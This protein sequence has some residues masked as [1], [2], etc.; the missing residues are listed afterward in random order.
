MS[1]RIVKEKKH[2][3]IIEAVCAV[4]PHWRLVF[5]TGGMRYVE[6]TFANIAPVKEGETSS[7]AEWV[8]GVA[9][10]VTRQSADKM[11]KEEGGGMFYD[12]KELELHAYDGRKFTGYAFVSKRTSDNLLPSK[13]YLNI[14]IDGAKESGIK[15]EYIANLEKTKYYVVEEEVRLRREELR[16]FVTK[17]EKGELKWF[18]VTELKELKAPAEDKKVHVCILGIVMRLEG[19][20][21]VYVGRDITNRMLL[22]Y[23]GIS[24]DL[25]DDGGVKF[26]LLK[27]LKED[28]LEYCWHWF[29]H[30]RAYSS[31]C[32]IVGLLKDF[33]EVN[34]YSFN[35]LF[36]DALLR[37]MEGAKENKL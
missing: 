8:H 2:V 3:P 4:L 17:K 19:A 18:T 11:I 5:N 10:K 12:F 7:E 30:F 26:P 15:P 36:K 28:E 6:P 27:D 16:E 24:M 23:H 1:A 33:W 22:H 14:L 13:R 29:D 37:S 35:N 34:E 31:G 21:G 25:H 9:I 20:R 32:E